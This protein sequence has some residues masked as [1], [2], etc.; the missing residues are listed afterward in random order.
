[1][2]PAWHAGGDFSSRGTRLAVFLRSLTGVDEELLDRI[3]AERPR[4][5]R[6]G[7][8]ILGT[9]GIATASMWLLLGEIFGHGSVLWLV[10]ALLWGLFIANLDMWLVASLHGSRWRTNFWLI[11]P[12][13]FLALIFGILIAEPFVLR[14]FESAIE[15]KIHDD[16]QE[17]L[18]TFGTLLTRC[19]PKSG[20]DPPR[21]LLQSGRCN[22]FAIDIETESPAVLTRELDGLRVQ[23]DRLQGQ[24]DQLQANVAQAESAARIECGR[25]AGPSCGRAREEASIERRRT[26]R[27]R[28]NLGSQVTDLNDRI[29]VAEQGR[30]KAAADYEREVAAA[31]KLEKADLRD[32]QQEVGLLE[33]LAALHTLVK[34]NW[35]LGAAEWLLRLLF[36]TIDCLPVLV[37]LMGGTSSYDKLLDIRLASAERLFSE[38]ERTNVGGQL[39]EMELMRHRQDRSSQSQRDALD[40]EFRLDSAVRDADVDAEIDRL[41]ARELADDGW[42]EPPPNSAPR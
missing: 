20:D 30:R 31:I 29:S 19:N 14:T 42:S 35:Y 23:R 9:A 11:L 12:R 40:S 6:L 28:R 27:Q 34:S 37:R 39:S 36:I 2:R 3:P 22:D 16:R 18:L 10:P 13:L 5:T 24:L 26:R 1:M 8:V 15:N 21:A 7:A 25:R 17:K 32:N 41:T 33:R 4:Y 38:E